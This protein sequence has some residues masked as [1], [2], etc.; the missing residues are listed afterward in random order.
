MKIYALAGFAGLIAF[1]MM[2]STASSNA[3]SNTLVH[4][5]KAPVYEATI[6]ST[7]E[8]VEKVRIIRARPSSRKTII[9]TD[10]T[11]PL[12]IKMDSDCHKVSCSK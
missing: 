8:I 9:D 11:A 7:I 2:A 3:A 4:S 10:V 6:G 1:A 12:T 5:E